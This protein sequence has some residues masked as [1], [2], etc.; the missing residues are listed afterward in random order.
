MIRADISAFHSNDCVAGE[1]ARRFTARKRAGYQKKINLN[2]YPAE[3]SQP[4]PSTLFVVQLNLF[5]HMGIGD[6]FPAEQPGCGA[7]VFSPANLTYRIP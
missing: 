3:R 1:L 6:I 4:S 2:Y 7:W 5:R